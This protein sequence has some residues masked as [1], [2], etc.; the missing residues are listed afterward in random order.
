[1]N[2]PHGTA[3]RRLRDAAR[4]FI[5]LAGASA[6][7]A[8]LRSFDRAERVYSAMKCRGYGMG[9]H[10]HSI[11]GW[12]RR[13]YIFVLVVCLPCIL[14]RVFNITDLINQVIGGWL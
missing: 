2:N 6:L 5:I 7:C 1:M 4:T 3:A 9:E 8:L 10:A 11:P 13:D 12:K 14:F